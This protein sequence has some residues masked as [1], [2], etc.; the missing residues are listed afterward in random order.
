MLFMILFFNLK[1]V[2]IMKAFYENRKNKGDF[3][4]YFTYVENMSFVAH[5]HK[6]IEMMYVL[7][8][9]I[10]VGINKEYRVL[11]KGELSICMSNDIHYYNSEGLKSKAAMIIFKPEIA[12]FENLDPDNMISV[13]LCSFFLNNQK[14]YDDSD[15]ELLVKEIA[16]ESKKQ[17]Q[18]YKQII[19]LKLKELFLLIFRNNSE[20]FCLCTNNKSETHNHP[21]KP[22]QKALKYLEENYMDE[23]SLES[24]SKE[25]GLSPFYFSRL[26]KNT[27]GTNYNAY[28]T[29][30]RIDDAEH[31]IKTTNEHII[32]IAFKTGFSSIRTFNR[33]FKNLKGYTPQ[34]I[35]KEINR[36]GT[37]K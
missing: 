23:V 1:E 32:D 26:F 5:W 34:S 14:E 22:M 18:L 6:E 36:D 21:L 13:G 7:D 4:V 27:T 33:A 37:F 25:A 30:L 12:A 9:E 16:R 19:N 10:G 3:P 2:K 20:Y 11:K 17:Q 29:Q 28:L 24:T 31:L 15:V 8:G 35:R